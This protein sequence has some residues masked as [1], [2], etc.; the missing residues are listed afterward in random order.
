MQWTCDG[1]LWFPMP[2]SIHI[3]IVLKDKI[4]IIILIENIELALLPIHKPRGNFSIN[5]T[6]VKIIH[7]TWR[8]ANDPPS[9]FLPDWGNYV[10]KKNDNPHYQTRICFYWLPL[11]RKQK[12]KGNTK[13]YNCHQKKEKI[14]QWG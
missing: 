6:K 11:S 1:P 3:Y 4:F 10:I 14:I 13:L 12:I 5:P 2:S 9:I 8:E 7:S